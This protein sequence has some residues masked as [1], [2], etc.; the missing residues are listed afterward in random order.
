MV[1]TRRRDYGTPVQPP[2]V[3][4][5]ADEVEVAVEEVEEE[6][7]LPLFIVDPPSGWGIG[8]FGDMEDHGGGSL[9]KDRYSRRAEGMAFNDWK[10]RFRS[11][12]RTMRQRNP[13]FN[14]WWAFEQLP[15]HL[16]FEALQSYDAWFEDHK[17]ALDMVEDYWTR[18]VEL[19]T[20]LKEG[21]A[22][23]L[24]RAGDDDEG[25]DEEEFSSD[26]DAA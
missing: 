9:G 15:N 23:P 19:V 8:A 20:A 24:A 7:H 14:D 16:E 25:D 2:V 12:Q 18:R 5:S 11:W 21:A 17:D 4:D 10:I 6:L 3:V 13:L 22:I 26:A 1:Q